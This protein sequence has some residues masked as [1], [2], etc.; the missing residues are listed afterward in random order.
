MKKMINFLRTALVMLIIMGIMNGIINY[1]F[2]WENDGEKY[3][4]KYIENSRQIKIRVDEKGFKGQFGGTN[5]LKYTIYYKGITGGSEDYMFLDNYSHK[6]FKIMR[7]DL[8]DPSITSGQSLQIDGKELCIKVNNEEINNPSYGTLAN[9]IHVFYYKG[10]EKPIQKYWFSR[11]EN[12]VVYES[13]E[14][15]QK[16]YEY[17]VIQYLTYV[18]S[19]KEFKER[20]EK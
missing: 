14:P 16:E 4:K 8:K 19:G 9:P 15:T 5:Y 20:F 12:K 10:I 18:M 7:F 11:A 17:N 13:I 6:Y 2:L 1:F 3:C